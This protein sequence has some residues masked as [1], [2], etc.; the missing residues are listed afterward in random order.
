MNLQ[1]LRVYS[2]H[3]DDLIVTLQSTPRTF[4][5]GGRHE[6]KTASSG[7]GRALNA[8]NVFLVPN[9]GFWDARSSRF[10]FA[11]GEGAPDARSADDAF[12]VTIATILAT[13]SL[14]EGRRITK[15]GRAEDAR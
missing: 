8:G 2:S 7:K 3:H 12:G 11:A 15:N 13:T 14:S 9:C 5:L 6:Q 4:D 10:R 1:T